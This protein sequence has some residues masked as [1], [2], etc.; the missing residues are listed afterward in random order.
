MNI[1]KFL[2]QATENNIS[3]EKIY[4]KLSPHLVEEGVNIY[5]IW[6]GEEQIGEAEI[7]REGGEITYIYIDI[8]KGWIFEF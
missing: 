5:S 1:I 4:E 7:E 3:K 8:W 2:F 6:E